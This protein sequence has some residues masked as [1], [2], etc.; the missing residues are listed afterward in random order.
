MATQKKSSAK[1]ARTQSGSATKRPKKSKTA[2]KN[3]PVKRASKNSTHVLVVGSKRPAAAF[4]TRIRDLAADEKVEVTL[5]LRGPVLPGANDLP[6][7]SLSADEFAKNYGASTA[8]VETVSSVLK[9]FG[10]SV[11]HTSLATRSVQV[12]GTAKQM[13]EAFRPKLGIYRDAAGVE[14]RDREGTYEVPKPLEHIVTA[15]IGFGQRPVARR[16]SAIAKAVSSV[17]PLVPADIENL[18]LFPSAAAGAPV[19]TIAIAEF[20]GG[21]FASDLAAYCNKHGRAVPTVNAISINRPAYTLEQIL[22]LPVKQR[23]EELDSSIEVMMDIEL[24]AGLSSNATL[25]VYFVTLDQ[26]GWVDLLNRTIVDRPV[27]LSVS[28]GLAEDDRG[29]SKAARDAINDRLNAAALLGITVCVASG[30]DG[31]GDEEV[32]GRAHVDFPSSSPFVLGVGGTML[33]GTLS[34]RSELVWWES[35][36]RRTQKGGGA[37]GGGV[38][39]LF[40]RPSWQA[41]KVASLNNGSIDG[42]VVPDVAALAG[43]PLYDLVMLGRNAP[44]GGTS[45]SAPVWAALIAR[46]NAN[47]H[48]DKRQRFLTPLLYRT[49]QNGNVLGQVACNDITSGNNA[50]HPQPGIGYMAGRGFDA[51]SGWGTPKGTALQSALGTM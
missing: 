39:A 28:W 5:T 26:K 24:I 10:L 7:G 3:K 4:A 46:I 40:P 37:T 25:N 51:V 19:Q 14:F 41:V 6:T 9:K 36:G 32:D 18:Y 48:T 8:D 2:T 17:P 13:E 20:G 38:S 43:D 30:D 29:W 12:S 11:T 27:A 34:P 35:P 33:K 49:A 42:R 21:Y 16:R 44:N 22:V 31:S 23:K 15:V 50:S 45:A 47:L 1:K